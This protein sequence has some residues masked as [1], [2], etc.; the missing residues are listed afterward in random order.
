M[1]ISISYSQ[2]VFKNAIL[3][4]ALKKT[5]PVTILSLTSELHQKKPYQRKT[6]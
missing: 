5:I 3:R 1:K 4:R 6:F 2:I